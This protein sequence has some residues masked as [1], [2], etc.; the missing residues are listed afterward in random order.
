MI[1]TIFKTQSFLDS[2][3]G[4]VVGTLPSKCGGTGCIPS[5]GAEIPY[6]GDRLDPWSGAEIPYVGVQVGSLVRG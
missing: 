5:Q 2:A 4:P 6:V 1:V 3:G